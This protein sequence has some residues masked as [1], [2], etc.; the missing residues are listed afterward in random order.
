M[1]TLQRDGLALV[2]FALF[3]RLLYSYKLLF[4]SAKSVRFGDLQ[5]YPGGCSICINVDFRY[6]TKENDIKNVL[7]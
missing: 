4:F 2:I 5:L 6:F 7:F 1:M 3:S